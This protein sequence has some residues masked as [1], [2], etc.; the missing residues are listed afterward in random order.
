MTP[1]QVETQ[2]LEEYTDPK[3]RT[4]SAAK[5]LEAIKAYKRMMDII[6]AN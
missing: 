4:L 5:Q 6:N 3:T 2:I 1:A